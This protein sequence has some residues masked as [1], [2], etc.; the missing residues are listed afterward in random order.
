MASGG[1][2]DIEVQLQALARENYALERGRGYETAHYEET[3]LDS[4]IIDLLLR[5]PA[6]SGRYL[7]QT[8]VA[9]GD[10]GR[11]TYQRFINRT[12][13]DAGTTLDRVNRRGDADGNGTGMPSHTA[14]ASGGRTAGKE[15]LPGGSKE[16][17]AARAGDGEVILS[18]GDNVHYVMTNISGAENPFSI[19]LK[20]GEHKLNRLPDIGEEI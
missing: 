15:L 17:A 1:Q 10:G 13:S 5:N 3:V 4:N 16:T 9:F 8:D 2:R 11:A 7:V 12:I 20:W 6:N 18:P 19:S 14:T